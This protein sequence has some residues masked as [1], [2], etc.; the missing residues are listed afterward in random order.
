MERSGSLSDVI[1]RGGTREKATFLMQQLRDNF[2]LYVKK[3]IPFSTSRDFN[4]WKS[5]TT[6]EL[7]KFIVRKL[8]SWDG[9]LHNAS[10]R[11]D[12]FDAMISKRLD[13]NIA[14]VEFLRILTTQQNWNRPN[15]DFN[16]F[17]NYLDAIYAT[18]KDVIQLDAIYHALH[19]ITNIHN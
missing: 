7:S 1:A 12:I 11:K 8:K 17:F 18:A 5:M 10:A 15:S 19:D 16:G 3:I 4:H 14:P 9:Q 6:L 13:L 2:G